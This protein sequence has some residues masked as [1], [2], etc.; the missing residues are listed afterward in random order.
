MEFAEVA[1]DAPLSL[2]NTLTYCIPNHMSVRPGN[3]V[4]VPLGRRPV[5][6]VVFS[7][8]G[9][10]RVL[11]PRQIISV[12]GPYPVLSTK[13]LDL[14]KWISSYYMCSLYQAAALFLPPGFKGQVNAFISVTDSKNCKGVVKDDEKDVLNYIRCK[15][16]VPE[17]IARRDMGT[18][19]MATLAKLVRNGVLRKSWVISRKRSKPRFTYRFLIGIL[20]ITYCLGWTGLLLDRQVC[21]ERWLMLHNRFLQRSLGQNLDRHL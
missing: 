19:K 9:L 10:P 17:N 15:V 5:Q 16:A 1:V 21:Y 12:I 8:S 7:V 4:W 6:G 13:N 11:D 20:E 18:K 14:A 2:E 3:L